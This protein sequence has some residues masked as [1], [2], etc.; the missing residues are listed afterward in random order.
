MSPRRP[1]LQHLGHLAV[2][3]LVQIE[4]THHIVPV[5]GVTALPYKHR[6][7]EIRTVNCKKGGGAEGVG[8]GG[9]FL[10]ELTSKVH[11]LFAPA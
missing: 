5:G 11:V 2:I 9:I 3:V 8:G 6:Y 1:P 4:H 10:S 7:G